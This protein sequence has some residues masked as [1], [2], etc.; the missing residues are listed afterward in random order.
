MKAKNATSKTDVIVACSCLLFLLIIIGSS[1]SCRRRLSE[2]SRQ[3][4]CTSNIKSL[5]LAWNMYSDVNND[6]IVNGMAGK[7][8]EQDGIVNEK[9]WT[10]RDW[11]DDYEAGA[12]LSEQKQ[13]QAIRDGALFKYIGGVAT[14]SCPSG[15]PGQ[16]RTYSIVDSMNGVP[17]PRTQEDGAWINKRTEIRNPAP[18]SRL[19]FIDVGRAT[20][21]SFAVHYDKEQWWA[22]PPVRH[23]E[24]TTV[25]FADG[26]VEYWEWKA[27]ETIKLSKNINRSLSEKTLIPKTLDGKEDLH[28]FQTAVWGRLGYIPDN[29]RE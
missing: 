4:V 27:S 12:H 1:G 28:K 26:H 15:L 19:V 10:G 22:Q 3:A 18:T 29:L 9:A 7:D 21:E 2:Q 23:S 5:A 13:E 6:K 14:Y 17:R 11:A 8:R 16:M 24:G 20:P 25:S